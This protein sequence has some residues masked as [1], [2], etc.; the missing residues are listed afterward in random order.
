MRI[1]PG[2]KAVTPMH[3]DQPV[4]ANAQVPNELAAARRS[5]RAM[6][7]LAGAAIVVVALVA[8]L[9]HAAVR[10][11]RHPRVDEGVV[12]TEPSKDASIAKQPVADGDLPTKRI[13][14][15]LPE[16]EQE[17]DPAASAPLKKLDPSIAHVLTFVV[18][19]NLASFA[20]RREELEPRT[21]ESGFFYLEYLEAD[22]A[23]RMEKGALATLE[24]GECYAMPSTASG[25]MPQ[26]LFA[27]QPYMGYSGPVSGG[28]SWV[29]VPVGDGPAILAMRRSIRELREL[30]VSQYIAD[31]NAKPDAERAA[32]RA[33]CA[34]KGIK[35]EFPGLPENV[36]QWVAWRMSWSAVGNFI[37]I[38][39]D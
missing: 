11:D 17:V 9:W 10:T 38:K 30:L 26:D 8:V 27:G 14:E 5:Y 32:L 39:A 35:F 25:V 24:R 31:F 23:W 36:S 13:E 33:S 12:S 34:G 18:S 16:P 37:S 3:D 6:A 2:P 19:T 20:K 29:A 21:A 22:L 28:P 4:E 1:V 15:P 7:W